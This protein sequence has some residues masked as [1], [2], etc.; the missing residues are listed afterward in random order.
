MF[1]NDFFKLN[2]RKFYVG[3]KCRKTE[4]TVIIGKCL[5]KT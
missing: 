2:I 5:Y 4:T 1:N 3:C